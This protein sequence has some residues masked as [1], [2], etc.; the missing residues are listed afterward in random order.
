MPTITTARFVWATGDGTVLI[1]RTPEIADAFH[2]L[3]TANHARLARWS[4]GLQE[5]TPEATR[6]SLERAGRAWLDGT[7]LP[8]AIGVPADNGH[9]L[10]GVVNLT[11]DA[12]AET[13]E[14]GFWIDAAAEGR[15]LVTRALTAVLAHAFGE[16][17]LH[18]V[19]M[20]TLTTNDRSRRLAERLGFTLEGVLREA[21]RFP[22]GRRDVA[23]YALLA[24]EF[25]RPARPR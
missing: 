17:G 22:D 18:R 9:R 15:G 10:V 13:G 6:G 25:T 2:A 16:I 23:C 8:L 11:I 1:P 12:A 5:P 20:R 7:R 14:V 3:L 4:P 21:A 19:E 24:E